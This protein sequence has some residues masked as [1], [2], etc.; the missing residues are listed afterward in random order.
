MASF[1]FAFIFFNLLSHSC[2]GIWCR[3]NWNITTRKL[4]DNVS[5]E[6]V[7]RDEA[8]MVIPIEYPMAL[9]T[10]DPNITITTTVSYNTEYILESFPC[11]PN[12]LSLQI[13]LSLSPTLEFT[14]DTQTNSPIP[15]NITKWIVTA[16]DPDTGY[17]TI[18][19]KVFINWDGVD[20][21]KNWNITL[22]YSETAINNINILS[23]P[24]TIYQVPPTLDI[25]ELGSTN[26]GLSGSYSLSAKAQFQLFNYV[27]SMG[28][29]FQDTSNGTA[30]FTFTY[31]AN[32]YPQSQWVFYSNF[33]DLAEP[34]IAHNSSITDNIYYKNNAQSSERI[35]ID[36]E[37]KPYL[38]NFTYDFTFIQSDREY[39]PYLECSVT[40]YLVNYLHYYGIVGP[41]I[42][43]ISIADVP[44]NYFNDWYSIP[45]C[46]GHR[47]VFGIRLNIFDH[48]LLL[49]YD[50]Y[51]QPNGALFKIIQSWEY[52]W[53][54][55]YWLA[56]WSSNSTTFP[57]TIHHLPVAD[58]SPQ[59]VNQRKYYYG[60]NQFMPQ[61]HFQSWLRNISLLMQRVTQI[62]KKCRLDMKTLELSR[63]LWGSIGQ[64]GIFDYI[65][66]PP[67]IFIYKINEE[68]EAT[69]NLVEWMKDNNL[70]EPNTELGSED[71]PDI[72]YTEPKSDDID[73]STDS[74]IITIILIITIAVLAIY[75][76][77]ISIVL[78][79]RSQK[80]R[81]Y[82]KVEPITENEEEQNEL[83]N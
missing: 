55:E 39:N 76:I 4:L 28:V 18:Y 83:I 64:C 69:L 16:N 57:T 11:D 49:E 45:E 22:N 68:Y 79:I 25:V 47:C 15:W 17:E 63:E 44:N 56:T 26:Y 23:V 43:N 58:C 74:Q 1:L 19:F 72:E 81:E 31:L 29:Y 33:G 50:D 7:D 75:S 20:E 77:I 78:W 59:E 34:L 67:Q 40:Q 8:P 73:S 51:N 62:G 3:V 41:P 37:N 9:L 53:S 32:I 82:Q 60:S 36:I 14:T 21:R 10:S 52:C 30:I 46:V 12:D 13:A 80:L 2:Y 42:K 54:L 71:G 38:M 24:I 6:S 35:F 70:V 48:F 65:D 27:N 66:F 5:I 61:K